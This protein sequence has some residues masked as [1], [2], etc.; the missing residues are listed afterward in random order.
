MVQYSQQLWFRR[1]LE[2]V[3]VS[4]QPSLEWIYVL[5]TVLDNDWTQARLNCLSSQLVKIATFRM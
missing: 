5:Q 3:T 2:V 1:A 4:F